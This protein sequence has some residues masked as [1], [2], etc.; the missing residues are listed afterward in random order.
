[1]RHSM[2]TQP[3]APGRSGNAAF[4][5]S[6]ALLQ[7]SLAQAHGILGGELLTY[8]RVDGAHILITSG[9]K[10]PVGNS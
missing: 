6:R 4:Q 8:V 2:L 1:M 9:G 5:A 10:G 7:A 3:Q